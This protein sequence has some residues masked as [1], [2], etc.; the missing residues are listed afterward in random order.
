[1]TNRRFM[2]NL[3]KTAGDFE[4]LCAELLREIGYR[5]EVEVPIPTSVGN[6]RID[7]VAS[8]GDKTP[9]YIEVKWTRNNP[10]TL[11]QLRD[12]S[13]RLSVYARV[14]AGSQFVLMVSSFV[15]EDHRSWLEQE[16]GIAIWD[17]G[18]LL[19]LAAASGEIAGR[20]SQ[21]LA[22]TDALQ[23]AMENARKASSSE[24]IADPDLSEQQPP[25]SE[26]RGKD[27]I[28]RLAE[29]P[30]GAPSAKAYESV[31]VEIID[32]L[33]GEHLLDARPQARLEDG[34]SILDV[35]YRVNPSHIFWETLTRDFR[36]RVIVFECKNYTDPVGPHQ[37]YTTER[38]I[39]TGALRP[40]CFLLTRK[41]P[42]EH[43]E[44]AAFGA[45]RESGKLLIFLSDK[46][47]GEMLKVRDAQISYSKDPV[48][49]DN[50]PT[51]LLDQKIY[52]FIARLPR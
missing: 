3:Q 24:A 49:R 10:A 32:Y 25:R 19:A 18:K 33:F 50:D 8:L 45:M 26:L 29:I 52:D 4:K 48:D 31:C 41:P 20:L 11:S 42:H 27:L 46:D 51:I 28:A 39:S 9:L 14:M 17:R 35:V 15:Q 47:L 1:M 43:A 21:F 16:F 7:I 34:L 22:D 5:T 38:Y 37:V 12:W 36:A 44:L 30:P 13:A 40:I 6:H 2:N 23:V